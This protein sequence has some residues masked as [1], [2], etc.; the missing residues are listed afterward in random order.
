MSGSDL[1]NETDRTS[2]FE[3]ST[4]FADPLFKRGQRFTTVLVQIN[5]SIRR[6]LFIWVLFPKTWRWK[7]E[8]LFTW[9]HSLCWCIWFSCNAYFKRFGATINDECNFFSDMWALGTIIMIT[10]GTSGWLN[11]GITSLFLT[12]WGPEKSRPYIASFHFT[13]SIGAILAP[14]LV[15]LYKESLI[16]LN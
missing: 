5:W 15:G 7:M 16:W 8:T 6:L 3:A 11:S 1:R 10:G 9:C 13:F 14:F 12:T 2:D 4:H